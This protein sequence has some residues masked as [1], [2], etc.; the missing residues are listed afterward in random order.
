MIGFNP[1]SPNIHQLQRQLAFQH[2]KAGSGHFQ[3]ARAMLGGFQPAMPCRP[4]SQS[5]CQPQVGCMPPPQ[6][7]FSNAPAGKGLTKN[8]DGSI[9]TAGGYTI[10]SEGK[11]AAWN[12]T[13]PDGKQLTRVW[14]DPHV[15]EADGTR[16]DFTKTS[17]FVLPDGTRINCKTTSETGKSVTASLTINNGNDLVKIDGIDK[18]CPK[19]GSVSNNGYEWRANHF[20]KNPAIDEFKLGGKGA[21]NV[22]W[23]KS[24][25]GIQQGLVTGARYDGKSKQYKQNV[26]SNKK[27]CVDPS[28]KPQVGSPAWGNQ[29]RSEMADLISSMWI[30]PGLKKYIGQF[31]AADHLNSQLGVNSM[32]GLGHQFGGFNQANQALGQLGNYQR[33]NSFANQSIMANRMSFLPV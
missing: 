21:G 8:K 2:I 3:Q 6:S 11:S 7:Q 10:R 12:I 9:T 20:S 13:G 33:A 17:D 19:T 28:M 31:L 14:G 1:Y 32:G 15:N 22:Q 4:F 5:Q 23:Y 29:I 16:W 25:S 24:T 18:N 30:H 27:Y 26:D